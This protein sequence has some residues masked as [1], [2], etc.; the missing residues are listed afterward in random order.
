MTVT[1][2]VLED[3]DGHRVHEVEMNIDADVADIDSPDWPEIII[4]S[5]R[6]FA[7][8]GIPDCDPPHHVTMRFYE[9][10]T[11]LLVAGGKD[12]MAERL[13]RMAGR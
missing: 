5:N 6:G 13:D 11:L 3:L 1:K 9:V 7:R 12:E 4:W 8:I 2:I 10:G